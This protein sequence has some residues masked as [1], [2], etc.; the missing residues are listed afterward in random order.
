[1]IRAVAKRNR[2]KLSL[3]IIG[4]KYLRLI[5]NRALLQDKDYMERFVSVA[6]ITTFDELEDYKKE[7]EA[8]IPTLPQ[9]D[10]T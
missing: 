4:G 5:T 10:L 1:M 8:S 9:R 6:G 2:E 7:R 3:P